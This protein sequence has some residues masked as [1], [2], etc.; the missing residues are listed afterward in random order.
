M[1]E[2]AAAADSI[3]DRENGIKLSS[4][5]HLVELRTTGTTRWR[6]CVFAFRR[7][8]SAR[9]VGP[10]NRFNEN[11][12][13]NSNRNVT[14][15]PKLKRKPIYRVDYNGR[16]NATRYC[17]YRDYWN[18]L[19]PL[20]FTKIVLV[21]ANSKNGLTNDLFF[22][23]LNDKMYNWKTNHVYDICLI[24]KSKQYYFN[25]WK[26]SL[27]IVDRDQYGYLSR[28]MTKYDARRFLSY[29]NSYATQLT[30]LF[31]RQSVAVTRRGVQSL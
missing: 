18:F 3:R 17:L 20:S 10:G 30:P 25:E 27:I 6:V 28:R 12:Y 4:R 15:A 5:F 13:E 8:T 16:T 29:V 14:E 24:T 1:Y 7:C 11:V 9:D 23:S 19:L 22:C 2:E 31:Y 21:H 26:L